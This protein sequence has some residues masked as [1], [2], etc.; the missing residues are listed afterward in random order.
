[1]KGYIIINILTNLIIFKIATFLMLTALSLMLYNRNSFIEIAGSFG[2]FVFLIS[3]I[4]MAFYMFITFQYSKKIDIESKIKIT[5]FFFF[6]GVAYVLA[7]IYRYM[8]GTFY[9][10]R[11]EGNFLLLNIGYLIYGAYLAYVD[12][13]LKKDKGMLWK[14]ASIFAPFIT[15][16]IQLYAGNPEYGNHIIF[17]NVI[18]IGIKDILMAGPLK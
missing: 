11:I 18:A 10:Q 3:F 12:N 16:F 7:S 4:V 1:M 5:S 17:D 15:L 6:T 13:V 14:Y 2:I 9:F 8:T